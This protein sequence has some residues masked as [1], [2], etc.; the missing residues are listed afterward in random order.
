MTIP[1]PPSQSPDNT[2]PPTPR[3]CSPAISSLITAPLGELYGRKPVVAVSFALFTLTSMGVALAPNVG[4]LLA[5]RFVS[6]A[7]PLSPF[8]KRRASVGLLRYAN[9]PPLSARA[10]SGFFGSASMSH[11]PAMASDLFSPSDIALP[12]TLAGVG[13]FGGPV[14]GPLI[15]GFIASRAGWRALGWLMMAFSGSLTILAAL[16][17]P[18][19]YAPAILRKRAR[20]LAKSLGES[21][22]TTYDAGRVIGGWRDECRLYLF[23]PFLFL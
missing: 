7:S 4:A 10:M 11:G 22:V 14:L 12:L 5:L 8:V 18:E 21:H 9:T 23:R 17:V 16:A 15:G 20:R 13:R 19:T 1:I 2:P 6:G 3:G